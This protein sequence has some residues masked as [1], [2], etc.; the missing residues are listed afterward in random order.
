MARIIFEGVAQR[1]TVPGGGRAWLCL[2]A[3]LG[4]LSGDWQDPV[5]A[6]CAWFCFA[7]L[8]LARAGAGICA[9]CSRS[10]LCVGLVA[11]WRARGV[12]GV[13]SPGSGARLQGGAGLV[14]GRGR[15]DWSQASAGEVLP[16]G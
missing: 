8:P 13:F 16:T 11:V 1:C 14:A 12:R 7:G 15:Q 6:C 5:V 3:L 4:E 10:V 9:L 2:V